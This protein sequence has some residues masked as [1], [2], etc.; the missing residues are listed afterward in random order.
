MMKYSKYAI[1]S[2]FAIT[3][4]I[5][6]GSCNSEEQ[7]GPRAREI[8]P[9]DTTIRRP[10]RLLIPSKDLDEFSRGLPLIE[11]RYDSSEL[12]S[13][14]VRLDGATILTQ[15][16]AIPSQVNLG[17]KAY[18]NDQLILAQPTADALQIRSLIDYSLI[19]QFSSGL[20]PGE[21][22]RAFQISTNDSLIAIIDARNRRIQILNPDYSVARILPY[23][24]SGFYQIAITRS[25]LFQ[26]VHERM[27]SMTISRLT[28]TAFDWSLP[29][30]LDTIIEHNTEFRGM[31]T[32]NIVSGKDF[33]VMY[34][35]G[36]R[37][38]IPYIFVFDSYGNR[39]G[40]IAF[41]GASIEKE[42]MDSRKYWAEYD[43]RQSDSTA[44]TIV[45]QLIIPSYI[46]GAHINS[47]GWLS[48]IDRGGRVL[49]VDLNTI[50]DAD[51]SWVRFEPTTQGIG[52]EFGWRTRPDILEIQ[53]TLAAGGNLYFW[54]P[55]DSRVIK[56]PIPILP[57]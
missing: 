16:D 57:D 49:V 53:H 26:I 45:Q 7:T 11:I 20:R 29:D 9:N 23:I 14:P 32:W 47:D 42:L 10:Y 4:V 34:S 19:H 39:I 22:D 24:N 15:S 48:F 8:A 54:R 46:R 30:T 51:P 1:T 13:I 28:K 36:G 21:F 5:L 12:K 43:S 35:F 41:T 33:F 44:V 52:P 50:D 31:S 18:R 40:L 2:F 3:V 25:A 56:Y 27:D 6:L 37:S 55:F 38:Q 17:L